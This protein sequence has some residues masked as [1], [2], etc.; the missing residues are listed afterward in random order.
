M[1]NMVAVGSNARF[2]TLFTPLNPFLALRV[3]LDSNSYVPHDFTGE[4]VGG[5]KR[6]GSHGRSPRSAGSAC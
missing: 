1:Q 2:T 4:N 6:C 3:L 5:S